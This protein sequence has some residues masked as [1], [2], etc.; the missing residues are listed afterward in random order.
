VASPELETIIAN[1]KIMSQRIDVLHE[2]FKKLHEEVKKTIQDI[3]DIGYI[4][5]RLCEWYEKQEGISI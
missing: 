1:H 2:E 3:K 4:Q 5:N